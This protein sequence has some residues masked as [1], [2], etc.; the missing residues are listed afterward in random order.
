MSSGIATVGWVSLS[1]KQLFSANR[2]KSGPWSR[3]QRRS[4][5]WR[6]A[7]ARKYCWRR[8]S[9]PAVLALVA[10][11]EDHRQVLGPILGGDRRG[12][13]AGVEL[14]QAELV[15]AARLP[16]AQRVDR[17]VPVT[18]D[19]RVVRHGEDVLGVR[20][21]DLEAA[22]DAGAQLG[23]AAE[24]HDLAQLGALDL[25]RVAAQQPVLRLLHLAAAFDALAEGAVLVA[26][27]VADHRQLEGGAGI[28]KAG[29]QPAEAAVAQRRVRLLLDQLFE[30][31][32]ELG[33]RTAGRLLQVGVEQGVGQRPPH[34]ELHRQVVGPPA[35]VGAAQ[36]D[37]LAPREHQ[38]VAHGQHQGVVVGV[39]VV[40]PGVAAQGQHQVTPEV[41][42]ERRGVAPRARK[43]C[44]VGGGLVHRVGSVRAHP[45]CNRR[46]ELKLPR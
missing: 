36:A 11:V 38:S 15:R 25:P 16:Q 3:I 7:L 20:P 14:L 39:I 10:R 18:G 27:A 12:V 21:A 43:I 9:A 32:A 23:P 35:V 22:V 46:P 2:P 4:T 45:A 42:A 26:Q 17:A 6:L 13:V 24:V 33:Q 41:A 28:E 29:G 40:A 5:S 44:K 31:Q 30:P 8:R 19:R 37:G 1:W 34:Q